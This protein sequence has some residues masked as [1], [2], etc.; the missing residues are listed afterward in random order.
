MAIEISKGIDPFL[1]IALASSLDGSIV[2][3]IDEQYDEIRKT[4]DPSQTRTPSVVVDAA[5]ISDVRAAIRFTKHYGL[6]LS[7]QSDG[8]S[9]YGTSQLE[10]GVL[11]E[12]SQVRTWGVPP[13]A[14]SRRPV[15]RRTPATSLFA[16]AD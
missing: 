1:M 7:I 4:V 8:I 6:P 2:L 11:V 16:A 5:S 13:Q 12:V 10:G 9:L 3:P 14:D 15:A